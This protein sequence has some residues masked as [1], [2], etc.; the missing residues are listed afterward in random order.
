MGNH[1]PSQI[2][3]SAVVFKDLA[4][5]NPGE[6]FGQ[7]ALKWREISVIYSF[8]LTHSEPVPAKR[9]VPTP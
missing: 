3:L 2:V 1:S 6:D 4:G 7:K 8:Q 9:R 5:L